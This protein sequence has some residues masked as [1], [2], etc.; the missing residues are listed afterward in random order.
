MKNDITAVIINYNYANYILDC[1][2][3]VASQTS[4]YTLIIIIDDCSSDDSLSIIKKFIK[5][6]HHPK[7]ELITNKK[8]L[9][10]GGSIARSLK[11]IKTPYVHFIDSDDFLELNVI[12][13]VKYYLTRCSQKLGKIQFNLNVL[14][15]RDIKG[16]YVKKLVTGLY[17]FNW[18]AKTKGYYMSPPCTGNIY[19][20]DQIMK[21][22]PLIESSSICSDVTL[23]ILAVKEYSILNLSE[24][25]GTYRIHGKNNF[26]STNIKNVISKN[27][28]AYNLT[29]KSVNEIYGLN[30]KQ[31]IREKFFI[32]LSEKL[33]LKKSRKNE[34]FYLSIFFT[35][36][37]FFYKRNLFIRNWIN[38]GHIYKYF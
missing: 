16:L 6:H 10:Q 18:E 35:L 19:R 30:L 29:R 31:K 7:I 38:Y 14:N 3:S 24:A 26:A 20:V 36:I 37:Y 15:E 27:I 22:I 8:N 33:K 32:F 9:G 2:N 23:N 11:R 28:Y 12:S 17:N 5:S 25:L 13:E 34:G 21:F 4:P 1:L